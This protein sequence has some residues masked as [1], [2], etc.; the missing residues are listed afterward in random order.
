M[1]FF[2]G[3]LERLYLFADLKIQ[4]ISNGNSWV[5]AEKSILSILHLNQH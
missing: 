3:T 5:N 1:D 4:I 2:K